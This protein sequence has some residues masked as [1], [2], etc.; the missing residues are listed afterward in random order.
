MITYKNFRKVILALLFVSTPS[1]VSATLLNAGQSSISFNN[2]IV[3]TA[4]SNSDN[5]PR[6][7]TY[8]VE[9][10]PNNGMPC[11]LSDNNAS[12]CTLDEKVTSWSSNSGS[13]KNS[14]TLD[15][16]F[17]INGEVTTDLLFAGKECTVD[18]NSRQVFSIDGVMQEQSIAFL[19]G[20]I[21]GVDTPQKGKHLVEKAVAGIAMHLG[22]R[23]H[24][25]LETYTT[26]VNEKIRHE[27]IFWLGQAR[28]KPGHESLI[29][30][31]NDLDRSR[32]E[33]KHGV[34]S[35]SVNSYSGASQTL[36]DYAKNHRSEDIQTE[37]LFWL[38]QNYKDK[39]GEAIEYVL[40]NSAKQS[41]KKK[42]VFS[43]AQLDNPE[44]WKQLVAIAKSNSDKKIQAEAIFWL[45]QN[46]AE[47]PVSVLLKLAQD[48]NP[49]LIKDKA[50]FSISQLPAELST[51]A[52]L[53]LI[54]TSNEKFVKKNVLF[55]LGQS[56]DPRAIEYLEQLL[57]AS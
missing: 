48:E 23:A 46:E 13:D 38:S 8:Q 44:G 12:I 18:A 57:T 32:I 20:I 53:E 5:Q 49:R 29:A 40:A 34:F 54:R 28:N 27:A 14:K 25:A 10:E 47:N 50:I 9:M 41:V 22:Q 55:W 7:F 37:S 17:R 43:L 21:A 4:A 36:V 33:R 45:S 52:L 42:A 19:E 24:S 30:I 51:P 3:S 6:W 56:D 16:Y 11:C 39:A 1:A 2:S 15:I 26:H 35:L 31:I